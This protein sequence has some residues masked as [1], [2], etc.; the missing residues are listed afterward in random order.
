MNGPCCQNQII[1]E[2]DSSTRYSQVCRSRRRH[3]TPILWQIS[4]PY[5]NQ[6]GTY[7]A[8]HITTGYWPPQIF[9]SS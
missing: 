6:G 5:L 9:K 1:A 7:Y 2:E 8:P 4:Q 3:G